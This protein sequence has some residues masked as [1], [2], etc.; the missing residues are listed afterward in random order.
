MKLIY[1]FLLICTSLALAPH[2]HAQVPNNARQKVR[3]GDIFLSGYSAINEAEKLEAAQKY[4]DAWNKYHQALRYYKTLNNNY[5]EWK[6]ELVNIR[7]KS[8]N[9]SI[10]IV[11][12]LAQ[13]EQFTKQEKYKKYI[14]SNTSENG[15]PSPNLPKLTGR[16]QQRVAD[17]ST[18]ERQYKIQLNKERRENKNQTSKLKR[19][20]DRLQASLLKTAQGLGTE[21]SQTKILNDQIRQACSITDEQLQTI[22]L[23]ELAEIER[24]RKH[25]RRGQ[26]PV[27]LE[28]ASVIIVDDG[29]ATGATIRAALIGIRHQRPAALIIAV[30]V[31]S[32]ETLGHLYS[33]VNDIVCLAK[34]DPLHAVGLYYD[35]FS[36]VS[37]QEVID[38]LDQR[39]DL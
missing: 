13:K 38:L 25:Y 28:G 7:M 34:P 10:A 33:E 6:K 29:I 39:S 32:P 8:T 17:L 19:E 18:K 35:D 26:K 36:Q 31:A 1:F 2:S 5:P 30:G 3:P 22:K 37:D 12:P 16:E 15:I 21:N 20:I 4:K 14:E 11:E 9:K 24:R 23:R 27:N